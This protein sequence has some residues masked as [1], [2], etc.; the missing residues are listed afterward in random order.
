MEARYIQGDSTGWL[1][2]KKNSGVEI[3]LPEYLKVKL[4]ESKKDPGTNQ[5]RDY[6]QVLEGREKGTTA[7][8][9][10]KPNGESWLA[11]GNPGYRGPALVTFNI[12]TGV[13]TFPGGTALTATTDVMNPVP[14]GLHD[15]ELP[16]APHQG[17]AAYVS[18]SSRAKTWFLIGHG[19][20]G[21]GQGRYLH[22]GRISAG[23]VTVTQVAN[24]NNLYMYLILSRKGD[25]RSVGTIN[26]IKKSG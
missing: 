13:V 12:T 26:V 1:R 18:A 15:L 17:G 5:V 20:L 8:V 23:C 2:V 19:L 24:W 16:D 9:R 7:S 22:P 3:A 25:D 10:Q 11:K 4:I 14:L 6:F 21:E